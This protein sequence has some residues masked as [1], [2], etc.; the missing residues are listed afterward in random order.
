MLEKYFSQISLLLWVVWEPPFLQGRIHVTWH[1]AP[2]TLKFRC[3]V[4]APGTSRKT[5]QPEKDYEKALQECLL[6]VAGA[7]KTKVMAQT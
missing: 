5:L 2:G 3:R 6:Q 4:P 7:H 1:K